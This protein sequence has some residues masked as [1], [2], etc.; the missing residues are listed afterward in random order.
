MA[1]LRPFSANEPSAK[2]ALRSTS[3]AAMPFCH[4]RLVEVKPKNDSYLW[5][6]ELYPVFPR[7]IGERIKKRRFDLKMTAVE[8]CKNLI[9]NKS[10]LVNW[11][12]GKHKPSRENRRRIVEFLKAQP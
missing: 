9:I 8:C 6:S 1:Q 10:T 3:L 11:E 4:L 2:P 12:R 5:K 7:H